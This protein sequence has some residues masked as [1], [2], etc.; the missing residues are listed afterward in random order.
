MVVDL[1][2]FYPA[3]TTTPPEMTPASIGSVQLLGIDTATP[4]VCINGAIYKG[5]YQGIPL[6]SPGAHRHHVPNPVYTHP[7]RTPPLPPIPAPP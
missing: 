7:L 2:D 4:F 1:C 5:G 6:P 3:G